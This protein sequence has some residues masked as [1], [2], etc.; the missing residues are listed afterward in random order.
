MVVTFFLFF[1]MRLFAEIGGRQDGCKESRCSAH[2]PVIRFPFRLKHQPNH[3]GYPGFEISCSEEK[4]TMLELP[5]SVKLSV[6]KINYT[7]QEIWVSGRDFCK[8]FNL[9]ASP[10][11][12]MRTHRFD[13][14]IFSCSESKADPYGD[15]MPTLCGFLPNNV[16]Y[17]VS[18]DANLSHL[19]LSSC[20]MIY[21]FSIPCE[22]VYGD[23]S[24]QYSEYNVVMNWS[25]PAC[26][27][28]EAKGKRCRSQE[29]NIKEPEIECVDQPPKGTYFCATLVT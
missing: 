14:I 8:N 3:C 12:F 22:Y 10:F 19:D 17:G 27:D 25:R 23:P 1:F 26:G 21:Y 29:S 5:Y 6:Q 15:L 20:S 24:N 16:V 2:G 18:P 11:Q 13:Y 4:R 9:S 7:S 28:C